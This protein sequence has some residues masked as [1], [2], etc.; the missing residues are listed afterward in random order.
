MNESLP[1]YAHI[2]VNDLENEATP[3]HL[4]R[5]ST[6]AENYA[7]TLRVNVAMPSI[8]ISSWNGKH[9]MRALDAP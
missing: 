8:L 6:V 1:E 4:I 3:S 2:A 5:N 9:Q 7:R